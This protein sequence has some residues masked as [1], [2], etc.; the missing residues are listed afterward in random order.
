MGEVL[1]LCKENSFDFSTYMLLDIYFYSC[2]CNRDN[3]VRER[4]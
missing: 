4:E 3:N 1:K 2:H